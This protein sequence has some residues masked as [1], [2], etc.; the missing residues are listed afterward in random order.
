L[1]TRIHEGVFALNDGSGQHVGYFK[2]IQ[3]Q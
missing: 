3:G 1:L 2:W